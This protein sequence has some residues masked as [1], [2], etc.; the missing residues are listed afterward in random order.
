M[1]SFN[2]A[3]CILKMCNMCSFNVVNE[4]AFKCFVDSTVACALVSTR[5]M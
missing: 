1:K 3:P 4:V 5:F 2:A